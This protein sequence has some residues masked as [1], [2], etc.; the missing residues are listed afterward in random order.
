MLAQRRERSVQVQ[1]FTNSQKFEEKC[2][3]L[4]HDDNAQIFQWTL[5]EKIHPTRK[6]KNSSCSR[7]LCTYEAKVIIKKL[8]MIN[9]NE[10][11]LYCDEIPNVTSYC[12]F[13]F[14]VPFFIQSWVD[15]RNIRFWIFSTLNLLT[16]RFIVIFFFQVVVAKKE[17][18]D[19]ALHADL[20]TSIICVLYCNSINIFMI[21]H[22]SL[23]LAHTF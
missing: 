15:V 11:N 2:S 9:I 16:D 3:K 17:W 13:M 10:G 22:R 14:H 8:F 21:Y 5:G 23:S 18:N 4:R 1:R 6:R 7:K 20:H 19:E 12:W